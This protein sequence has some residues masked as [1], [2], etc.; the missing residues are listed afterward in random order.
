VGRCGVTAVHLHAAQAAG[1][2]NKLYKTSEAFTGLDK[3]NQ[4]QV[5]AGDWSGAGLADNPMMNWADF[6]LGK[7]MAPLN[8][9]GSRVQGD[10]TGVRDI[11]RITPKA[12]TSGR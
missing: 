3:A 12:E 9:L 11:P 10:L 7:D 1:Q 5:L 4:A 8:T 6:A 2:Y